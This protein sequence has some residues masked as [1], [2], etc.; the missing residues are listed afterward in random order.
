MEL[1]DDTYIKPQVYSEKKRQWTEVRG[2]DTHNFRGPA[3][4]NFTWVKMDEP[5]IEGLRLALIDGAASVNRNMSDSP[6]RHAELIIE[7]LKIRQAKYIG[8]SKSLHCRFSPFLNTIIGGRGSGKS[9]LLEFMRLALRREKEMKEMPETLE[10]ESRK[11]FGT[12]DE[13]LLISESQISLIYRKGE[14]R[15][16]L[17][18]S[19]KANMPPLEEEKDGDW[20][21][22]PGEIRS[23]FPAYI[24]SQK[25]IFELARDPSALLDIVD[26]APDVD[27][28]AFDKKRLELVN[29]Y[30]QIE[31]NLR[32]LNERIAQKTGCAGSS[33][34]WQD[35]LRR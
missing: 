29:Q 26:E 18:W 11:Y 23:L 24:Y 22:V 34:I 32:E 30:K 10:Q 16:R 4:G 17:N 15:Y 28:P 25:Q 21:P 14:V 1:C 7:K 13:D 19:A 27:Y 3:F 6:N 5:S 20:E 8:R 33:T 9:T 35:R 12:G 31:Q 2:S